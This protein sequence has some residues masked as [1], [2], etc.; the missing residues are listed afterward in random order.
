MPA[1]KYPTIPAKGRKWGQLPVSPGF[2]PD[3][4]QGRRAEE[5]MRRA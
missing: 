2:V 5:S 3:N 1:F 4:R